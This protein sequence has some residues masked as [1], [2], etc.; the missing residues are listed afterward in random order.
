MLHLRRQYK[1]GPARL[2]AALWAMLSLLGTVG[3]AGPNAA[4]APS[5]GR[6]SSSGQT[7]SA[8]HPAA[9][10]CPLCGAGGH[11]KMRACCLPATFAP[12]R[13]VLCARCA[14]GLPDA[15]AGLAFHWWPVVASPVGQF[16]VGFSGK[17]APP[18]LPDPAALS[19]PLSPPFEPP[20]L[21]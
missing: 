14:P 4:F 9:C 6:T 7:S 11:Q 15:P 17:A 12:A 1:R 16:V 18:R 2:L 5:P 20:R 8:A 3:T 21:L 10:R 19:A 13:A